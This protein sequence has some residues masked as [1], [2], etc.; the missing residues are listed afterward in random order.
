MAQQRSHAQCVVYIN[1]RHPESCAVATTITKYGVQRWE[2]KG[3][4]WCVLHEERWNRRFQK[5]S[6]ICAVYAAT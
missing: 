6:V 4:E 3:V 1:E 2:R 5:L